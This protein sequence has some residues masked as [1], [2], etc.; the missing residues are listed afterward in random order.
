M[1]DLSRFTTEELLAELLARHPSKVGGPSSQRPP[2]RAHV[3]GIG[4]DN[5]AMIYLDHVD[6]RVL[7]RLVAR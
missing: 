7:E 6:A 2:E 5:H 4:R 3:I 1:S